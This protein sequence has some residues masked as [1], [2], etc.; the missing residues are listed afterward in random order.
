M[1][2]GSKVKARQSKLAGEGRDGVAILRQC[3]LQTEIFYPLRFK[4]FGYVSF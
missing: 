2:V 4:I 3:R 1:L